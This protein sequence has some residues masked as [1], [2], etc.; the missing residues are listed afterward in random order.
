MEMEPHRL[1]KPNENRS[2][3]GVK[4]GHFQEFE[5]EKINI[6]LLEIAFIFKTN[7][8]SLCRTCGFE[9][10]KKADKPKPPYELYN[11]TKLQLSYCYG[12]S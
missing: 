6:E 12:R 11:E 3:R 7:L 8:N 1:I 9:L 10:V 4:A 5:N 2:L